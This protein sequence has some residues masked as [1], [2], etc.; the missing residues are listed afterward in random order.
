MKML[1]HLL[2]ANSSAFHVIQTAGMQMDPV[3]SKVGL[4]ADVAYCIYLA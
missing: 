4:A 3:H 2:G 1:L